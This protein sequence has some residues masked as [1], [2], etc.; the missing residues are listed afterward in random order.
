M[1][2]DF[3]ADQKMFRDQVRRAMEGACP[4]REVRRVLESAAVAVSDDAWTALCELGAPAAAIPAAY[5]GLGAG[6]YELC[7]AAE[8]AGRALAP[9]GFGPSIFLAAEA[10]LAAGDEPQKSEWLP[11]LASG[12]ITGCLADASLA[13]RWPRYARGQLSGAYA[14]VPGGRAAAVAVAL[15]EEDGGARSLFLVDLRQA[16]VTRA[17]LVSVDPSRDVAKLEFSGAAATRLGPSGD[18]AAIAQRIRE[19]AAILTAFEQVGGAERAL[20]MARDYALQRHAFGR[21]IGSY[22]AIKH[23]L[24]N[25]YIKLEIARTHAYYGAWALATDAAD[26]PLAAAAARV[27]ATEAFAFA[28]QENIQTHGGIGFT[29]EADCHLFYRRARFLALELGSSLVWKERL[30]AELQ[31]R[32]AH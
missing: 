29:W 16:G 17:D 1:D 2:F 18:G 19:R 27:S 6:Y 14:P 24:A 23:K 32:N 4:L 20:Y 25:V 9:T 7:V 12:E 26:L 31:Q 28:A 11:R 30:A 13:P 22:Q 10:L 21:P 3:S 15:A 5:G 8:E